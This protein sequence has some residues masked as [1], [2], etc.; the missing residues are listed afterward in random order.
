MPFFFQK[1]YVDYGNWQ[2]VKVF[3]A[4]YS[5]NQG[6]VIHLCLTFYSI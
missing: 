2:G 6:N 1:V 5:D 3:N 4:G